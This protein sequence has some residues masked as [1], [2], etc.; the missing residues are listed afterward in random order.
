MTPTHPGRIATT[1]RAALPVSLTAGLA[2]VLL[3]FPPAQYTFYPQCPIY[4]SLHLLCP[5]CGGTHALAALLH[6]HLHEALHYNAL[7]TFLLPIAFVYGAFS[8]RRFLQHRPL[9]WPKI[10]SATIHAALAVAAVFT[11]LRNLP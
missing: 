11:V 3:R 9:H 7:V 10:P 8:Y 6:G 1:L 5:G 4:S 2:V